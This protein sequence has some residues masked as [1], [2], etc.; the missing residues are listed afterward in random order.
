MIRR[1]RRAFRA[2]F[3]PDRGQF[4][5]PPADARARRAAWIDFLFVDFALLRLFWKNR[6]RLSPRAWRMNQ[7]FPSDIAWAGRRGIRTIVTARH[8]PRHGGNAL[9][10]EACRRHGLAYVT[11]PLFSRAAP[12]R[13]SL[14]AAP[15]FFAGLA[16]PALFH[17]KS[18]ADRAGLL[19]ALYLIVAEG[20]P[21]RLARR[22]LGLR[23]L[24]IRQSR[25]G[26][27]DAVFDAYLAA[28]PDE[29]T[30]FLDWVRADYDPAAIA[31]AHRAGR[32]ADL[33]DRVILR[34]E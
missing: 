20:V 16:Y 34:R 29:T 3:L 17:C 22:Q 2:R 5:R 25:T 6:A 19:A 28:H 12:S 7:P 14:L 4:A 1:L 18:G 10:A 32:L 27:L 31:R 15:D 23:F 21:V 11:F 26:V 8:D 13:E 24:H 30:P 9:V 33:L